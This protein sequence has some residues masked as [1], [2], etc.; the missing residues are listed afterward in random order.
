MSWAPT[1]SRVI[2]TEATVELELPRTVLPLLEG[3]C[4]SALQNRCNGSS[5]AELAFTEANSIL[6]L[7]S[8]EDW[9]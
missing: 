8:R 1:P 3:Q 6:L 5:L 9:Y 7:E 2:S 4:N